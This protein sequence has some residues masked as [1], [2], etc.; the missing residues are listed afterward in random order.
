MSETNEIFCPAMARKQGKA[1]GRLCPPKEERGPKEDGG[2]GSERC[3]ET[4]PR[5]NPRWAAHAFKGFTYYYSG[6][7]CVHACVCLDV[8]GYVWRSGDVREFVISFHH[9][10]PEEFNSSHKVC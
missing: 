9:V 5:R 6:Y 10:D 3:R 2:S 7:A 8:M 1:S 4:W